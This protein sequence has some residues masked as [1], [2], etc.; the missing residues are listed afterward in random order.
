MSEKD[1]TSGFKTER[2]TDI[3]LAYKKSRALV[4]ALDL[5]LFTHIANG[6]DTLEALSDR[7]GLEAERI[8]RLMTVLKAVDLV[9]EE[10]GRYVNFSDVDRYLVKGRKTYFGDYLTYISRRDYDAWADLTDNLTAPPAGEPDPRT[11]LATMSDPAY[12]RE[13]TEAGYEASLPLGYKLAREFDFGR[14]RRWLDIAGGSGCYSIAACER[15]P[16]L[17]SVVMDLDM[18]LPVTM[19][20]VRKHGLEGRISTVAGN[21]LEPGIPGGFDLV[22]FITPLQGYM[23]E[24]VILALRNAR[25]ALVP[26]GTILIIDYML[27]EE[28][29]GPLDPAYVNLFGICKGEY[30]NRVN[31]GSEWA[32]FLT[33]AGYVDA[34]PGWFT[35]HQLGL[36]TARRPSAP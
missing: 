11:Y 29:N 27:N 34:E 31:T 19:E 10:R 24:K 15:Y 25:E 20:Y 21:F 12:A 6:A 35:P 9:R 22:S 7:L 30:L 32:R 5:E 18:V 23:P 14:F 17:E 1:F 4:T 3:A 2:M 26:G 16:E 33:E 28:K 13:F 8:D 36:V